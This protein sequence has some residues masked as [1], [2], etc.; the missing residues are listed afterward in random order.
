MND[1]NNFFSERNIIET[2]FQKLGLNWHNS[3]SKYQ[4]TSSEQK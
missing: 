2:S 1:V 4:I 3:K